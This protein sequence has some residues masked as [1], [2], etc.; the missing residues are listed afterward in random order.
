MLGFNFG[1]NLYVVDGMAVRLH[2][3]WGITYR[4]SV[5]VSW[6]RGVS[7]AV[8]TSILAGRRGIGGL[9]PGR[10]IVFLFSTALKIESG[11]HSASCSVG[12]GGSWP[13]SK[14]VCAWGCPFSPSAETNTWRQASTLLCAFEACCAAKH[15]KLYKH[16]HSGY[17][18]CGLSVI[19]LIFTLWTD[20]RC[21]DIK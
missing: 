20:C 8:V 7:V 9:M 15:G 10:G 4:E 6:S 12:T 13:G 1:L 18:A 3:M 2:S 5:T 16:A 17:A 11:A 14:A 19:L 21:S